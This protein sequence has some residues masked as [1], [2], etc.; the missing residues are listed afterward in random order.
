M[1]GE[2]VQPQGAF[3]S[4]SQI[5]V[6]DFLIRTIVKGM[7]NTAIP[8][9]VDSIERPA[10]GSGAG[11]LSATPLVK[12]RSA[13]G[14]ALDP[15][16]IPKLRWFRLQ[17]GTA[18]LICDPK[19]GDVGLAVFAQQDVS[20]LTGGSDPQQPGSFRCY[21]MS[22][23]FYFGGFWGQ[24][25]TTFVRIEDSGD[26]TITAPQT[27]TINTTQATINAASSC[28]VNTQTAAVNADASATITTA[29]ATID[30]AKTH[31]TGTLQVDGKITG[32]GGLAVSGGGG[33]TV[34][35]DVVADGISLKSHVH[36][37]VEPG[38]GNTGTPN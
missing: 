22:D 30:A 37:G 17:H 36:G 14:K 15:V 1:S 20:T 16:S 9:R 10:D 11:Y 33:A 29:S 8:V 31:I 18:A 27:V 12:M 25:P 13:S 7:V 28:E 34:S 26:V 24:T 38:S 23:G 3:V 5:N 4:G 21:D 2:Y 35:G 32:S 6:L 19:P